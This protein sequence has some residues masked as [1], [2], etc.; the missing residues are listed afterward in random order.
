MAKTV[1]ILGD[2]LSLD[3]ISTLDTDP[4]LDT[5]LMVEDW[6]LVNRKPYHRK[7]IALVWSAMRHF[8]DQLTDLG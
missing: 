5:I 7:K 8:R 2:Q 3:Y 4:N 1:L 6:A